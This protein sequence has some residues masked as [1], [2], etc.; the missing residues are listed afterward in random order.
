MDSA[1]AR[2]CSCRVAAARTRTMS[3]PLRQPT[4]ESPRPVGTRLRERALPARLHGSNPGAPFSQPVP[5]IRVELR[6][7]TA[8]WPKARPPMAAAAAQTGIQT[9]RIQAETIRTLVVAEAGTVEL[10]GPAETRGT[11][12]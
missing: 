12:T 4:P 7:L 1:A 6:E 3:S 10:G 9:A 5:T 8:A 11:P 2:E